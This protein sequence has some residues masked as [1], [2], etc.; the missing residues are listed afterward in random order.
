MPAYYEQ[1]KIILHHAHL[2]INYVNFSFLDC[3]AILEREFIEEQAS[4]WTFEA[5]DF[6]FQH[7]T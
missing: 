4:L 5:K 3:L 1:R 6:Q 7:F 2:M